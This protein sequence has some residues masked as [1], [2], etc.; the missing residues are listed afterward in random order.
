MILNEDPLDELVNTQRILVF[1][2]TRV[3][4]EVKTR[5]EEIL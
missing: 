3:S 4:V 2:H 5:I 1:E